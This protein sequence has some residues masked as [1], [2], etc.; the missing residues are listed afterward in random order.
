MNENDT[1]HRCGEAEAERRAEA[2]E[3]ALEDSGLIKRDR[4]PQ[5]DTDEDTDEEPRGGGQARAGGEFGINGE[6]Y[7]GGQFMA[8]HE[9]RPKG[10]DERPGKQAKGLTL[11]QADEYLMAYADKHEDAGVLR[12]V[13]RLHLEH[14]I[15]DSANIESGKDRTHHEHFSLFSWCYKTTH[16]LTENLT[17]WGTLTTP[18]LKLLIRTTTELLELI[19]NGPAAEP[20]WQPVPIGRYPMTGKILA[21]KEKCTDWGTTWKCLIHCEG[22]FK[23][24]GT[25]PAGSRGDTISFTAKVEH[26]PGTNKFGFFS[27]PTKAEVIK[28]KDEE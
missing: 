9:D 16:S 19:E 25:L 6:W 12:E 18:Q 2:A 8:C 23:I 26:A 20:D 28:Y 27:R 5:Q 17:R 13:A 3:L 22:D 15:A 1:F 7:E 11:D 21:I 10:S 4:R 14:L 24:W